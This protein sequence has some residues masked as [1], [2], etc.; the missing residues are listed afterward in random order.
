MTKEGR[1]FIYRMVAIGALALAAGY[2]LFSGTLSQVLSVPMPIKEP[3]TAE[4]II[5]TRAGTLTLRFDRNKVTLEGTLNR[6]TPCVDWQVRISAPNNTQEL[7]FLV[8]DRNAFS[9]L[10][11]IQVV[12]EP[13]HIYA[14]A[15]ASH[16]TRYSVIF[17]EEEQFRGT[18]FDSK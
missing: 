6:G 16:L 10:A 5:V 14:E 8:F 9:D 12:A 11:C 15:T 7:F 2:I 1:I 17:E 13:Q 18:L 3:L 4:R